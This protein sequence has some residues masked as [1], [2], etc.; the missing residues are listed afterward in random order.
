M[1]LIRSCNSFTN[2][3]RIE[4]KSNSLLRFCDS[5]ARRS[6]NYPPSPM[7]RIGFDQG[8]ITRHIT[9]RI[10]KFIL[11][12]DRFL[13]QIFAYLIGEVIGH[14][15]AR[16]VRPPCRSSVIRSI[17]L[18]SPSEFNHSSSVSNQITPISAGFS[19]PARFHLLLLTIENQP[20]RG[21]C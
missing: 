10:L 15:S 7:L 16:W 8:N 11:R 18:S 13:V 6:I 1:V 21:G 4:L 2:S 9:K 3:S 19:L 14:G 5:S 17:N 12:G 20:V